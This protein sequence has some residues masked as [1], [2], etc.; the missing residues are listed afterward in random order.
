MLGKRLSDYGMLKEGSDTLRL[1]DIEGQDV[2]VNSATIHQGDKGEF[3]VMKVSLPD[4]AE[5]TVVTGGFLILDAIKAVKAEEGF[6]LGATF[7]KSGRT[8][9]CE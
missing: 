1:G 6:P 3:V 5:V 8:W 7:S 9:V 4:G 2:V